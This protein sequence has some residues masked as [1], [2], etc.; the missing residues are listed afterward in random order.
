M[1]QESW[2]PDISSAWLVGVRLSITNLLVQNCTVETIY[3]A[4]KC[5]VCVIKCQNFL[6]GY[7]PEPHTIIR[8][9]LKINPRLADQQFRELIHWHRTRKHAAPGCF[10]YVPKTE[11]NLT[12]THL[13][14]QKIS[15]GDNIGPP[16]QWVGEGEKKGG[17]TFMK[18]GGMLH[19]LRRG[20]TPLT[21]GN[22]SAGN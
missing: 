8:L 6:G 4:R 16:L 7:T 20:W 19:S 10:I 22:V 9:L 15:G 1:F 21:R 13:H 17:G 12:C 3:N 5:I 11:L 14:F 18:T 2:L